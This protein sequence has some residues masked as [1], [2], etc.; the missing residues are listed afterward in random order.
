MVGKS[1]VQEI[2][3]LAIIREISDF[4]LETGRYGS[5]TVQ[6]LQ[7]QVWQGLSCY[8]INTRLCYASTLK[9]RA[10]SV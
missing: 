3:I 7:S 5:N 8:T 1:S 6:N 4:N 9:R 2:A 10:Y